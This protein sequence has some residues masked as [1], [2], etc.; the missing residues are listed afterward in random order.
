[1][2]DGSA[3]R[4]PT[5]EERR[6]LVLEVHEQTGHWGEK[7]TASLLATGYWWRG[8]MDDVRAVVGNCEACDKVRASFNNR[9]PELQPLPIMGLMF[10]WGV[11]L[12]GPFPQTKRG[13][14]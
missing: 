7:R 9:L 3:R 8:M 4:V 12:C 13:N 2:T 5:L 1:M 6:K 14:A 11:D 10:R